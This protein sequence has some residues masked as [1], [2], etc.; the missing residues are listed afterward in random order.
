M[1]DTITENIL[2]G[3]GQKIGFRNFKIKEN[4]GNKKMKATS[5]IWKKKYTR[6][7]E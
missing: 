5:I 2:R 6:E 1:L 3:I 4:S 7:V